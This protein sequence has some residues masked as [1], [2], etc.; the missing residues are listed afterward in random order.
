MPRSERRGK[1]DDV[2]R[3]DHFRCCVRRAVDGHGG[4]GAG[5]VSRRDRRRAGS[6]AWRASGCAQARHRGRRAVRASRFASGAERHNGRS[7]SAECFGSWRGRSAIIRTT[8]SRSC[9]GTG[10]TAFTP[11]VADSFHSSKWMRKRWRQTSTSCTADAHHPGAGEVRR[12]SLNI[13]DRSEVQSLP[14]VNQ[15]S[16]FHIRVDSANV[17]SNDTNEEISCTQTGRKSNHQRCDSQI[18]TVP[19]RDLGDQVA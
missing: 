7:S 11:K 16:V 3:C 12:G 19:E 2:R 15:R 8:S 1:V 13:A 5:R 14:L 6:G 18:E 17:F 4:A 10:T 9:E